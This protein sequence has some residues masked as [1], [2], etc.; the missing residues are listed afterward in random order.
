MFFRIFDL[1]N[2]FPYSEVLRDLKREWKTSLSFLRK[3]SVRDTNTHDWEQWITPKK[4]LRLSLVLDM[5]N[6][7]LSCTAH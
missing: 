5:G 6:H 4:F 7:K 3:D 1:S 2:N